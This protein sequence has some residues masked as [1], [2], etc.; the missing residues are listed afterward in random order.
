VI[1]AR[2]AGEP[3]SR[4]HAAR[5]PVVSRGSDNAKTSAVFVD[6]EHE[7]VGCGSIIGAFGSGTGQRSINISSRGRPRYRCGF[8]DSEAEQSEVQASAAALAQTRILAAWG[9]RPQRGSISHSSPSLLAAIVKVARSIHQGGA[10]H[11]RRHG[12]WTDPETPCGLA[13]TRFQNPFQSQNLSNVSHR[14][15]FRGQHSLRRIRFDQ[16]GDGKSTT[17]V[18]HTSGEEPQP[19]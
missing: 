5:A 18:A 2:S 13:V 6:L 8:L 3:L 15:S 11:H 4:S 10:G 7:T 19:A 17:C 16:N 14:Q 1:I 12:A 9:C